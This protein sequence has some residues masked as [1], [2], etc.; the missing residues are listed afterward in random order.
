MG[1]WTAP[2]PARASS[3]SPP[4]CCK[5]TARPRS[6]PAAWPRPAGVQA[7]TLYRL[8]G[9]KDGLLEA[10]AEQVMSTYVSAKAEVVRAASAAGADPVADLEAGWAHADRLRGSRTR[11]CSGCSTTPTGCHRRP[12]PAGRCSRLGSAGSP[13]PACSACPSPAPSTSS[14]PPAPAPSRPCSARPPDERDLGLVEQLL[15]A[16]LQQ[17]L[18]DAPV[19]AP[20]P[21]RS[22]AITLGAAR[23]EPAG[24]DLRREAAAGRVAR[25]GLDGLAVPG[26]VSPTRPLDTPRRGPRLADARGSG[27]LDEHPRHRPRPPRRRSRG[28]VR[29]PGRETP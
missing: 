5:S 6:P 11:P 14:T 28:A 15:Q 17:I 4:G 2:T 24:A 20:D 29:T 7:P 26:R 8:F 22:A 25:P 16:V 10:V 19:S 1:T 3:T 12:A 18:T 13:R 23:P 21:V 27:Q 9:D